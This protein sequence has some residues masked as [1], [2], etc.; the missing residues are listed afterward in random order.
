MKERRSG[1]HPDE[2]EKKA[3]P[4]NPRCLP[5]EPLS[6]P[7]QPAS[8]G[9]DTSG[10]GGTPPPYADSA[11]RSGGLPEKAE[12]LAALRKIKLEGNRFHIITSRGRWAVVSEDRST[13]REVFGDKEK[14]VERG[15]TLARKSGGELVVHDRTGHVLERERFSKAN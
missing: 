6:P 9:G 2:E 10:L 4:G 12:L 15:R 11:T 8:S 5:I 1:R 14:A 3:E 13:K 7:P